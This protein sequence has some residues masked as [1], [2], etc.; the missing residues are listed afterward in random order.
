MFFKS[1]N[2]LFTN[3]FSHWTLKFGFWFKQNGYFFCGTGCL[4][5]LFLISFYIYRLDG[6]ISTVWE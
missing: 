6:N 2:N 3:S 4:F 1:F 5:F